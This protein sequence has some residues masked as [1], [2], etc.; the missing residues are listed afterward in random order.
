ML[1]EY[2]QRFS[3][4]HTALQR[5]GYLFRSGR[6]QQPNTAQV[7]SEFSD[8]FQPS[9]IAELRAKLTATAE[10]RTTERTS[11]E[12][13]LAFALTGN[14][15][16]RKRELLSELENYEARPQIEWNGQR[17]NLDQA[18]ELMAN[19]RDTAKRHEL[20]AR[21]ADVI[22]GAQDF[23]AEA[24]AQ[25]HAAAQEWDYESYLAMQRALHGVA[26]DPLATA[27]NKFLAKTESQYV[28]ALAPLLARETGVALDA[29]TPADLA[30]LKRFTRFDAFFAR[31]RMLEIY[32]DLFA[33]LGF[34]TEKQNNVEIDAALRP[35]KQRAAFC[36]PLQV[37]D[38]IKLVVNP[39]GGQADY[40]AFLDATGHAQHHAWTSRNLYPEFQIGGDEAVT[41]AWG[42]LFANL[43]LDEHWLLNTFGF[44]ESQTFRH[45]LAVF[46]LS[47][48][49]QQAALLN[50]E[51]EFHAGQLRDRAGARYVELLQDATRV[52]YDEAEH[53]RALSTSLRASGELRAAAFEAQLRDHL[54]TKFGVRWWATRKAGEMLI[55]LWNVGQRHT[56]EEL[57]AL[58]GL[59]E[60]DFDSLASNTQ[61][62]SN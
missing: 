7:W 24:W 47:A 59:G 22:R 18:A 9:A 44:V 6:Q 1:S 41:I 34:R 23:W 52:R 56:L 15:A 5:A 42:L 60:L 30:Y 54:K 40:R 10:Y 11:I 32:R 3:E 19:E 39:Q 57:A 50:Y 51:V 46:R 26:Y 13:L 21:R 17:V 37:P 62:L 31:E 16:A 38:E 2:R 55:D 49:R 45:A 20:E 28:R 43:L 8:L 58:I 12:R 35:H 25:H 61:L 53:L 14:I 4:I 27:A 36:A 48:L 33:D 29:A